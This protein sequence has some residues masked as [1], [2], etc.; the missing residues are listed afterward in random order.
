[1]GHRHRL[2]SHEGSPG[3]GQAR[4]PPPCLEG[5]R[6][7]PTLVKKE[8][9]ECLLKL[10]PKKGLELAFAYIIM[11]IDE[12]DS[13]QTKYEYC[14]VDNVKMKTQTRGGRR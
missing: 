4:R 9:N 5:G 8:G 2:V 1:V 11:W 7:A 3:E 13:M 6:G 14:N 12:R 10:S